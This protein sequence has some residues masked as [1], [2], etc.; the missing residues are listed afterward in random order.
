MGVWR[1]AESGVEIF[2]GGE[3]GDTGIRIKTVI[4]AVA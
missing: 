1:D 3:G 4:R 2:L